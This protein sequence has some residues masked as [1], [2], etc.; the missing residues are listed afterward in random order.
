MVTP[1]GLLYVPGEQ[2]M[3]DQHIP[4]TL[5]DLVCVPAVRKLPV[6]GEFKGKPGENPAT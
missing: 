3:F 5:P 6:W 1:G 4:H 2:V